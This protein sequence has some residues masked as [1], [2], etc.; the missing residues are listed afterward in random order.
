[1]LQADPRSHL[2]CGSG[3]AVSLAARFTAA[4][5]TTLTWITLLQTLPGAIC[6]EPD[7]V[8]PQAEVLPITFKVSCP[9]AALLTFPGTTLTSL[10]LLL[11]PT[12]TPLEPGDLEG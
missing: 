4:A 11:L 10:L 8:G 12:P 1:M 3:G 9:E 6:G 2:V 7:V 5:R